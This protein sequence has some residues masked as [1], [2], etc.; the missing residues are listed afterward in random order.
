MGVSSLC[1][2]TFGSKREDCFDCFCGKLEGAGGNVDGG[3]GDTA[4]DAG[5]PGVAWLERAVEVGW[6]ELGG[7]A[8][9]A[10]SG[11]GTAFC[12]V[13]L[14]ETAALNDG[15]PHGKSHG[16]AAEAATLG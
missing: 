8:V 6:S 14:L 4:E 12:R 15:G 13:L 9:I 3:A 1:G 16:F 7:L 5:V 10:F 11:A 2:L